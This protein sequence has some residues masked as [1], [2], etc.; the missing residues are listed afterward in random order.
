MVGR[1]VLLRVDKAPA[2]PGPVALA[3]EDLTVGTQTTRCP[4]CNGL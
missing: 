1:D 4:R 3:V 2:K